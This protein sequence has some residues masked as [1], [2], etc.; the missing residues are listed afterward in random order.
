MADL[1]TKIL[2]EK[3]HNYQR[4]YILNGFNGESVPYKT[5]IP[6][7]AMKKVKPKK[8]NYTPK[9]ILRKQVRFNV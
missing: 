9:N 6:K 7:G 8:K 2:P 4:N 3:Q 1:L 5:L